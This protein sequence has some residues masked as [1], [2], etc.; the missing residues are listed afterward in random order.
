MFLAGSG[1]AVD[2]GRA[3][4][5][6]RRGCSGGS[7]AACTRLGDLERKTGLEVNVLAMFERACRGGDGEGCAS[8]GLMF[9]RGEGMP[10]DQAKAVTYYTLGCDQGSQRACTLLGEANAKARR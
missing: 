4:E 3:R 8:Y 10:A 1:P 5:F 6:L 9:G 2:E 7:M